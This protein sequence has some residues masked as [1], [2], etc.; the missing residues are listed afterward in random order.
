MNPYEC[1]DAVVKWEF[2]N[3]TKGPRVC[4]ILLSGN[5][6][7]GWG[8]VRHRPCVNAFSTFVTDVLRAELIMNNMQYFKLK[9][10]L[11]NYQTIVFLNTVGK[12]TA[13]QRCLIPTRRIQ[14]FFLDV[15]TKKSVISLVY[16]CHFF[17]GFFSFVF[18]R[19]GV[20]LVEDY[21]HS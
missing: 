2:H 18:G 20:D 17:N 11:A 7:K 14:G 15:C 12:T 10:F 21:N 13:K 19:Y 3:F 16:L 5:S 8:I 4:Y 6:Q 1:M 9:A